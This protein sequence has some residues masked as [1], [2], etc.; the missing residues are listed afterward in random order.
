M[1]IR[2]RYFAVVRERLGR[3]E[4]SLELPDDADVAAALEALAARHP[5]V[6][7]LRA[8]LQVALNQEI[9]EPRARVREGDELALIPPVAGCAGGLSH[10]PPTPPSLDVAARAVAGP[11]AVGL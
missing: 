5:V 2:V 6:R 1:R 7:E 9:T 10:L 11:D 8:H 3:E 4:E